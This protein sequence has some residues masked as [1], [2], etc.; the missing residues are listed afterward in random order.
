MGESL[1]MPPIP[2]AVADHLNTFCAQA[3]DIR[4]YL[5]INRWSQLVASFLRTAV[6]P[7]D[8]DAFLALRHDEEW[9][10]LS[11]RLGHVQGLIARSEAA[12]LP[13]MQVAEP[14]PSKPLQ[15]VA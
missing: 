6:S 7:D 2:K 3:D 1:M 13:T 10:Q 4:N 9:E 5:Q 11:M 12:Q 8:A 15:H 14:A